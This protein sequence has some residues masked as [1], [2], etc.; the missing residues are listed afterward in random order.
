MGS[1]LCRPASG[2]S[3]PRHAPRWCPASCPRKAC[4]PRTPCRRADGCSR[5]SWGRAP[6]G[7]L[8]AAFSVVWPAF[9]IDAA[10]FFI[11][12]ALILGVSS[13]RVASVE[14]S[15]APAASMR[16]PPALRR[17]VSWPR[18]WRASGSSAARGASSARCFR[19]RS[20]CSGW[21]LSTSSSCRCSSTSCAC[22][23]PGSVRSSWHRH[24]R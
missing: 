2:P 11:S 6:P 1:P 20:S 19:S 9:V 23:R 3:S 13:R 24:P 7:V 4:S 5:A 17:R 15:A 18:S 21:E 22:R 8:V 16:R 12:F 14:A 10:T